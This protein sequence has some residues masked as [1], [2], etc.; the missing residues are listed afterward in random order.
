MNMHYY[1]FPGHR[2]FIRCRK[3]GSV[4]GL[5]DAMRLLGL[6]DDMGLLERGETLA[7]LKCIRHWNEKTKVERIRHSY[8]R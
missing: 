7:A 8:Y 5:Q 2:D 1:N 4:L 6:Q 3:S